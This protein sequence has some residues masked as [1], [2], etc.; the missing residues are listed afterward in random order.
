M[1]GRR[2]NGQR[3]QW[4]IWGVR[5]G[6]NHYMQ[7]P[8][9]GTLGQMGEGLGNQPTKQ[10]SIWRL[11]SL[12]QSADFEGTGSWLGTT[13]RGSSLTTSPFPAIAPLPGVS[14]PKFTWQEGQKRL[15][16]IGC[17][18]LLIVLVVSLIILCE[19]NGGSR[20]G[21]GHCWVERCLGMG[22]TPGREDWET[23]PYPAAVSTEGH[24]CKWPWT[25]AAPG[26][27]EV[28]G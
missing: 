23:Y 4:E 16:L 6:R 21:R 7:T 9:S 12:G 22:H 19:F 3:W 10:V 24:S 11:H 14:L 13:G 20:T 15:P 8:D 26:R 5:A 28:L 1:C 17:V 2:G 25:M 18:L 27:S